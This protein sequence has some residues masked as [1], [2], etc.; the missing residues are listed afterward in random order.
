L[1]DTATW[2][3]EL[4][5]AIRLDVEA[6]RRVIDRNQ[7]KYLLSD[8][9]KRMK[10]LEDMINMRRW[11]LPVNLSRLQSHI[12]DWAG[13]RVVGACLLERALAQRLKGLLTPHPHGV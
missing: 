2:A 9:L 6:S 13:G 3:G 8:G 5:E 10:V 12:Y 1:T 11:G 7:I 4:R